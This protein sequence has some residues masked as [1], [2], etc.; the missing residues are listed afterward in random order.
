M[1]MITKDGLTAPEGYWNLTKEEKEDITN[2]AGPKGYGW[3]VPDTLWGL[4]CT[5]CFNIHDYCYHIWSDSSG[6]E[7]ADRLMLNNLYEYIEKE[8]K[9]GWYYKP[10][11]WMR[12]R[13][14]YKYYLA[15]KI[16][17]AWFY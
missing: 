13:R 6:K 4:D 3:I 16:G 7:V 5:P 17:G 9:R 12:K 15:V 10:L 2:S 11:R 1:R 14:A 8:T